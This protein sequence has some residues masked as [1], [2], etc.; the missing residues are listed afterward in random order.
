MFYEYKVATIPEC[1][2]MMDEF[3]QKFKWVEQKGVALKIEDSGAIDNS[4]TYC[5]KLQ[6]KNL[7]NVFRKED[8]IYIFKHHI[9]EVLAGHIINDWE[10]RILRKEVKRRCKNYLEDE[11]EVIFTKAAGILRQ[12]NGSEGLNMLIS[13]SRKN[14]MIERILEHMNNSEIIVIEG[15]INF[16]LPD[17]I[18]EIGIAVDLASEELKSEKE[19]NEFIKLLSYF[20]DTQIPKSN[21][22]NLLLGNQGIFYL[23]DEKGNTIEDKYMNYYL[24][25]MLFDDINLD[26][27]II[28]ILITIA[29]RKIILHNA[30]QYQENEAV[31]V[32][33][34]V[35]KDRISLCQSC[36]KCGK[37]LHENEQHSKN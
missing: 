3:N 2:H 31:E 28:S 11:K 29:P 9:S 27:I 10:E 6:V 13:F 26:D 15:F 21:E 17:Y 33:R 18:K 8:V 16:C 14:K 30:M 7:D 37:Y 25:D 19:Y 24:E 4:R 34:K 5:L 23:W 20:V 22:V 12:C 32:I 1:N 36:D 35:F